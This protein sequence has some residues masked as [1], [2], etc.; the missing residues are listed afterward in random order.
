MQRGEVEAGVVEGAGDA[1]RLVTLL[2]LVAGV[3][4]EVAPVV[5]WGGESED[6]SGQRAGKGRG[7]MQRA[8]STYCVAQVILPLVRR[9]CERCRLR[10]WPRVV[11]VTKA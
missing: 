6:V 4:G 10:R 8:R 9:C 2:R 1:A 5:V 11:A 3:D 7:V